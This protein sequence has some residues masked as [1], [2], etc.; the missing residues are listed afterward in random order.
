MIQNKTATLSVP[1]VIFTVLFVV[2][3]IVS[4]LT[5]IKTVDLKWFT[6]T[7]GVVVFPISYVINDCVVEVYGLSKARFMIWLGFAMSLLVSLLLNLAIVLPGG[8]DWDSQAAMEKI[9][10]SVPR[11]IAASLLAFLLGSM[12]NA[13]IMSRLKAHATEKG[14]NGIK[15]FSWRAIMSSLIGE[16]CDSLI[17]FPIAFGGV[18]PWSAIWSLIVT[19][20]VLKT[21]YEVVVL[22]VTVVVVR[23]LK[24]IERIDTVYGSETA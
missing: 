1:Y 24:H 13:Y 7:A 17:F 14:R 21:S 22:P 8:A 12:A 23:R 2:C 3:L 5:E 19:Q 10:G 18:L 16:G 11:I 4:N 20:A 6:I 9:Y 15:S